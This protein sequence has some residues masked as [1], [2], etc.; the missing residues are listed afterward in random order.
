MNDGT[1]AGRQ[2]P[3]RLTEAQRKILAESL[4]SFADRLRLDEVNE[5][6]VWCSLD[7]LKL[8]HEEAEMAIGAAQS[9]MKR[10]SLR[11]IAYNTKQAIASFEGIG[12]I[13]AK[14]RIYQLRIELTGVRPAIWRR[15]QLRDCVLDKLHERI[16]TAMGWT[17][18][19][20][21][22]FT[23]NGKLYG[24][25]WLLQEEFAAMSYTNSRNVTLS[26]IVPPSGRRFR[27]DYG[28]DFGDEWRHEVLFEGC[29]RAEPGRRYP[30]CVEGERACPPEDVGGVSGY[31]R[32]VRVMAN[33]D[34]KEHKRL[35]T[36]IG[37]LFDPESFDAE[38]ATRRMQRGLPDWRK[39]AQA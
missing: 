11:L 10:A 27:F 35:R 34:H 6:M 4:P 14:E 2:F 3:I 9:G 20:L 1:K 16:Q 21:H 25:P 39:S 37:G 22:H 17:N 33:S 13:P 12:A 23:I 26:Q 18:S 32:F 5:R 8:I 7:E 24:D 15:I 38:K 30:W 29:L 36:W 28:Y 19:H 31:A